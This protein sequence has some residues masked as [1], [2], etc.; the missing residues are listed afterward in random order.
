[1]Q[2]LQAA[3]D[4]QGPETRPRR[5]ESVVRWH[6]R[7]QPGHEIPLKQGTSH[8]E[9]RTASSAFTLKSR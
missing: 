3:P 4:G 1:V 6:L 9:R 5:V 8:P 2:D 7:A